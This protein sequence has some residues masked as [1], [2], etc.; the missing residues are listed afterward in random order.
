MQMPV[1][2]VAPIIKG[3][4]SSGGSSTWGDILGA[5]GGIAGGVVGGMATGGTGAIAGAGGGMALGRGIGSYLDEKPSAGTGD[6]RMNLV[7]TGA[8]QTPKFSASEPTTP[9]TAQGAIAMQVAKEMP[10]AQNQMALT[11]NTKPANEMNPI[12]KR[13]ALYA[14]NDEETKSL[15]E[16][17]KALS[18]APQEVQDQYGPVLAQALKLKLLGKQ[19]APADKNALQRPMVTGSIA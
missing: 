16:G 10:A 18:Q 7:D 17:V 4:S 14:Q 13:L 6:T 11:D 19:Q 9:P 2:I 15:I 8:T 3:T 12:E 5:I 1:K